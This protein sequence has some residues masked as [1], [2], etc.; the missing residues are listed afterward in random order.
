MGIAHRIGFINTSINLTGSAYIR[1]AQYTFG[2]LSINT[3]PIFV[4]I[5]IILAHL[6]GF[7]HN[8]RVCMAFLFCQGVLPLYQSKQNNWYFNERQRDQTIN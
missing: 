2:R 1:Q 8:L 4:K 7:W 5:L 6:T 3:F